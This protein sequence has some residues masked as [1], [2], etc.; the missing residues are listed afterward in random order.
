MKIKN[1]NGFTGIDAAIAIG[2][3]FIFVTL[4]AVLSY[5]FNSSLEEA[6]L[7][8]QALEIAVEQIEKMKNKTITELNTENTEYRQEQ[9]IQTGYTSKIDVIDYADITTGKVRDI[10]K[11][12]TV[13]IKYKFKKQIQSV[14]LSTII[15]KGE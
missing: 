10:V 5:N 12:I 2:V 4:I 14:E 6:E 8:S 15:S 7:K 1:E 3:L 11:K 13:T 9:E